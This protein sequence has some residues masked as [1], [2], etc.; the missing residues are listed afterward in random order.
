[1]RLLF[2]DPDS[3]NPSLLSEKPKETATH[4]QYAPIIYKTYEHDYI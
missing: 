4:F 3:F 2:L 1:M